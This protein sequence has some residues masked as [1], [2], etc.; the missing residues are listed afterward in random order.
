MRSIDDRI[1]RGRSLLAACGCVSQAR[2]AVDEMKRS[3]YNEAVL[4]QHAPQRSLE[5]LTSSSP[6]SSPAG[7]FIFVNYTR[8]LLI[9]SLEPPACSS[10][11]SV[12]PVQ[13]VSYLH[14]RRDGPLKSFLPLQGS[15]LRGYRSPHRTPTTH[16]PSNSPSCDS[17][18]LS[19]KLP[20]AHKLT[21]P[22]QT[23]SICPVPRYQEPLSTQPL[24]LP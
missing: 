13:C 1:L 7:M 4:R 15:F 6:P 2:S 5:P 22:L 10:G 16:S 14:T 21:S 17:T 18:R 9:A 3:T 19:S 20:H 23:I 11:T 24:T 8:Q 12:K